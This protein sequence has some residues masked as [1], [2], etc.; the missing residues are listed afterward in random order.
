MSFEFQGAVFVKD[1]QGWDEM[2]RSSKG[3]VGRDLLARGE[4]LKQLAFGSIHHKT[5]RLGASLHINYHRGLVNPYVEIGSPLKYAYSYH[6]GTRP[7]TIT[8][9]KGRMVRFVIG[10][11]VVYA[12]KVHHPG[13]KPTKFLS[14]HL[15]SIVK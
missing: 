10:G 8:P 11:K 5:G 1:K 13:T 9:H 3:P 2:T 15:G 7:H 12:E 4:K 14:R 6:E